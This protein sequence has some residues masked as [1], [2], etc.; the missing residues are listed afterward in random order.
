MGPW[1]Q[2]LRRAARQY[3]DHVT[4]NDVAA[5]LVPGLG[6][7]VD[8]ELVPYP[9]LLQLANGPMR[10]PGE[11]TLAKIKKLTQR[12]SNSHRFQKGTA[13][14]RHA[15]GEQFTRGCFGVLV[16]M[17]LKRRSVGIAGEVIMPALVPDDADIAV[18][19]QH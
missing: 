6:I 5:S 13:E 11:S 7:D 3:R 1:R 2:R 10:D 4:A 8:G 12:P 15:R 16:L 19:T 18:A 14:I 17:L 9:Q